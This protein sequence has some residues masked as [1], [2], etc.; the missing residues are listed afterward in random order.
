M[1]NWLAII[2]YLYVLALVFLLRFL[3]F[4]RWKKSRIEQCDKD[5]KMLKELIEE[6]RM[7]KKRVSKFLSLIL[8]HK[9]HHIGLELSPNGWAN[10]DDLIAKSNEFGNISLTRGLIEEVVQ[11]NDKQRFSIHD[12]GNHIRANQGH[13][14]KVDLELKPV[15]PPNTLY[16][17]TTDIAYQKIM[18]TNGIKRM[19]RLFV[20][21]SLDMKT[22]RNV[23]WRRSPKKAVLLHIDSARMA[24]KGFDFYVSE[25]GV[26]LTEVVPLEYIYLTTMEDKRK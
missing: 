23:A 1:S 4:R 13:S 21:L 26:W 25:N 5:I 22:A 12:D 6:R 18:E 2:L 24:K 19:K 9:P 10:I 3:I 16:H 7:D 11:D 20:H 14:V 15:P 8:R 17:G